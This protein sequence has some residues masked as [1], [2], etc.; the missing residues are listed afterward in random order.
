VG[1][2]HVG[3]AHGLGGKNQDGDGGLWSGG[4]R[5]WSGVVDLVTARALE[6]SWETSGPI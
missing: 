5:V 2:T 6:S 4:D 1:G 3:G